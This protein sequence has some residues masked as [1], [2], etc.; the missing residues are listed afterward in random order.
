MTLL[1]AHRV[2]AYVAPGKKND[3]NDAAAIAEAASRPHIQP[4]PVKSI[5]QQAVLALH[6]S[7]DLLVRQRT[8]L[9]NA[10]RGHLA[11]FPASVP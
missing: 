9:V 2:K 4:I 3:A 6:S 8:A 10:L 5:E 7:R 11:A 1:P